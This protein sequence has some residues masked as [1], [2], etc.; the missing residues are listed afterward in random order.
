MEALKHLLFIDIETACGYAD[1]SDM[2]EGLYR[3]WMHKAKMKWSVDEEQASDAFFEKAAV[4]A[5]FG[6]IV[7]ISL[8]CLRQRKGEEP[9]LFMRSYTDD[10]E[11]ALLEAFCA[12]LASFSERLAQEGSKTL[13]F[14]GHNIREFDLPYISRRLVIH[15]IP[16]PECLRLQGKKPWEIPHLDTLQLWSFGDHKAFT[17]LSLLAELL[18]IPS[19]KDDISGSDVSRVYWREHDLQRIATYCQKDVETT[20]RIYLRLVGYPEFH[21]DIEVL[22]DSAS[23]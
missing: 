3:E 23:S 4:L 8:G 18:D 7:C 22:S 11:K 6:K 12:G 15:R 14:V 1:S 19:P 16:F 2:S 20:A 9:K 13:T 21:F 5:E 10:D 17:R